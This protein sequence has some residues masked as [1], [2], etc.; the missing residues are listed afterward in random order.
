ML[1][2][3]VGA[4]PR[5]C[6]VQHET[7]WC[8]ASTYAELY[9][10]TTVRG[11]ATYFEE[12]VRSLRKGESCSRVRGQARGWIA[13]RVARINRPAAPRIEYRMLM[14]AGSRS[15]NGTPDGGVVGWPDITT[16]QAEEEI[17]RWTPRSVTGL[18]NTAGV[19]K[20]G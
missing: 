7:G 17:R 4:F 9:T 5:V 8:S 1:R 19:L 10:T 2:N 20:T 6:L 11:L 18:P 3:A 14:A 12:M 15:R 13:E 16:K